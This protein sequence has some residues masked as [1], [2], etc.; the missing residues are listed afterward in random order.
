MSQ[1]VLVHQPVQ[2]LEECDVVMNHNALNFYC[3]WNRR[4]HLNAN[5]RIK[6]SKHVFYHCSQARVG[7]QET[8]DRFN[9]HED[10]E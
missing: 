3:E 4:P 5:P 1:S 6:A 7:S 8:W 2:W 10:Y 9:C